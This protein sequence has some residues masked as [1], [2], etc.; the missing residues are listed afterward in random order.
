MNTGP[1]AAGGARK[2]ALIVIAAPSGA[3]KT[4]L[5]HALLERKPEIRFSISYTTRQR[6][7]NEQD[8]TAYH[9]VDEA[10]FQQMIA[11]GRFLEHAEVFDHHYGTDKADVESMRENGHTVLLEIDWQGARQIRATAPDASFVFVVPPG[12]D[13]LAR[14]LRGRATDSEVVI[15]R[16]LRDS[17]SDLAHWKEFDYVIV[18]DRLDQAAAELAAIVDGGGAGNRSDSPAIRQR[19]EAMLAG[20]N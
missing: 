1:V 19:V 8:G 18:N 11:A 20:S 10:R 3:G 7:P 14:R 2:G 12:V 4:S 9:F 16:R 17:L 6:R 13:E 15:A 5:V